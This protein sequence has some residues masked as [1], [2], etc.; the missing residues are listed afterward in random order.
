MNKK[1]ELELTA[2]LKNGKFLA[3]GQVSLNLLDYMSKNL[4]ILEW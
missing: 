2:C 3:L 4:F 1:T